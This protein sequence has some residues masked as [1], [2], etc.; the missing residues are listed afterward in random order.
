MMARSSILVAVA[1]GALAAPAGAR[2]LAAQ[3]EGAIA[4]QARQA[5]SG[6]GLPAVQ[7]LVDDRIGA[8]T[9]T[10]GRYRARAVR[11]GWHGVAARLI[12]YRGVV[13]DS[14]FVPAGATVTVDFELEANPQELEPLVVRAPY[15]AVLDPLATSTEQKISA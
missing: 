1:L 2:P 3:V 11:A 6:A 5:E 15:D 9:D 12:G 13:F 10:A 14:V 4:G 8:V 7:V